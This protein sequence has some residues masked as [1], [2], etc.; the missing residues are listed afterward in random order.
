MNQELQTF[1]AKVEQDSALKT[2]V[3]T[4]EGPDDII[5]IANEFGYSIDRDELIAIA[6]PQELSDDELAAAAGGLSQGWH[7]AGKVVVWG[8]QFLNSIAQLAR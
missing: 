7:T 6:G 8:I 1:F 4:A 5:Q 2:R 3:A